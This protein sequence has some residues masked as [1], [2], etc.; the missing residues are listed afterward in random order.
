M[1][2]QQKESQN[3]EEGYE[4]DRKVIRGL[5]KKALKEVEE[6]M[7]SREVCRERGLRKK[8]QRKSNILTG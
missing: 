6:F 1:T 5:V 8:K 7:L 3:K 4:V 2:N